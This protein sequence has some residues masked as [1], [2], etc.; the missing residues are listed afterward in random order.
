MATPTGSLC[1]HGCQVGGILSELATPHHVMWVVAG[2]VLLLWRHRKE[3]LVVETYCINTNNASNV[4]CWWGSYMTW[5]EQDSKLA[6]LMNS[7]SAL[8]CTSEDGE[9]SKPQIDLTRVSTM[10]SG[11]CFV[12]VVIRVHNR[13]W[14]HRF[15]SVIWDYCCCLT[16]VHLYTDSNRTNQP[17]FVL[18]NLI[19]R[20]LK[21]TYF[22]QVLDSKPFYLAYI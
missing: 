12:P 14:I 6:I 11:Q 15:Y 13:V 20:I 4:I 2:R 7:S 17:S 9:H 16:L 18:S 8:W 5:V 21:R 19:L 1:M 10:K 3:L 22:R